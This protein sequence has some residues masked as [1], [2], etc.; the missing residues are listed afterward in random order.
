M[1]FTAALEFRISSQPIKLPVDE[2]NI[3]FKGK[4]CLSEISQ[5]ILK[6]NIYKYLTSF[7]YNVKDRQMVCAIL[8]FS[9]KDLLVQEGKIAVLNEK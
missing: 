4:E 7:Q 3:L 1:E 6:D 9:S 8:G 2:I 5:N